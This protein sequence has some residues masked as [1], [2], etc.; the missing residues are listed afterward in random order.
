MNE[1]LSLRARLTIVSRQI[2][3]ARA[4]RRRVANRG[5]FATVAV[6][7]VTESRSGAEDGAGIWTPRD[8]ARDALRVLEVAAAVALLVLAV[9]LPLALLAAPVA[10]A[11]RWGT[12]RR[13]ER[14]LDAV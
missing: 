2:A 13:R 12:R 7:L 3:A 9:A 5:A 14:A 1:T 10:L 11:A 6:E 4:A 8:A